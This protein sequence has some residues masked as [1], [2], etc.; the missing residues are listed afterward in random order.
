[1]QSSLISGFE[2]LV[3][4]TDNQLAKPC[5]RAKIA[6]GKHVRGSLMGHFI[7]PCMR[8]VNLLFRE[9]KKNLRSD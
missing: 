6:S 5:T 9:D 4:Q 8:F 7:P 1:M 3:L 2:F